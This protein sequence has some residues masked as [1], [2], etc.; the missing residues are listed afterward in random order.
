MEKVDRRAELTIRLSEFELPP[1]Q[2]VLLIGRRA[3]IGP[4]A[5]RR[6]AEALAPDQY[7]VLRIPEGPIEAVVVR[8][9]LLD[10]FPQERLVPMLLAEVT[11]FSPE[12]LVVRGH[13]TVDVV[14][15]RQVEL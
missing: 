8:K 1:M 3:P 9:R 6:M 4:E 2:D 10:F 7:E 13:I 12:S 11:C 15:R 5:A 14:V